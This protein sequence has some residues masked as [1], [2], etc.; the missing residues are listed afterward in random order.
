MLHK[1]EG[2]VVRPNVV[3]Y[4]MIVD[5]LCKDGLVTEARDLYS[6]V[7]GR[8]IDPDVFTYTCLIHGF[9]P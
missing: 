1:M 2:Q 4:N 3:I 8:G 5:G 7:V 6:D 9:C